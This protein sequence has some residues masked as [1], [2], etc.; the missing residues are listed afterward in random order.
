MCHTDV[1]GQALSFNTPQ[2]NRPHTFGSQT[3]NQIDALE[4]AGYFTAETAPASPSSMPSYAPS[5]DTDTSLEWRVRSYL[6]VN[7]AQCHQPNGAAPGNWDAR[8]TTPTDAAQII[9]GILVND[10]GDPANRWCVPGDTSHSVVLNRL[11]GI[12]APRMPPLGT[13]ERDFVSEQLLA[14]WIN[15]ALPGRESFAQWQLT[16]FQSTTDP[17]AQPTEDPDGDGQ[18]NRLE[19]LLGGNPKSHRTPYSPQ[20]IVGE[21]QLTLEF[22]QPANRS[23]LILTSTDLLDWTIW[24]IPENNVSYPSAT[25]QRSISGSRSF[26]Q[27]FFRVQ[28]SE[29]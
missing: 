29:P 15:S 25:R 10:I 5:D 20:P 9:N 1:G 7:C 2:L 3:L 21:T 8:S 26:E 16:H 6:A 24:D 11:S 19:F 17:E 18:S 14:D 23:A 12:S 22:T 4:A 28:L 27:Q 13:N